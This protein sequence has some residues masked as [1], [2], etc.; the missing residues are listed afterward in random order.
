MAD[1]TTHVSTGSDLTPKPAG[2][3]PLRLSPTF[4]GRAFIVVGATGGIGL[5]LTHALAEAGARLTLV[6]RDGARL[7]TLAHALGAHAVPADATD[8]AAI[9][10]AFDAA[11]A[12]HGRLDGAVNLAG[13]IV[14]KSAHQTSAADYAAVVAQN[15]TTAFAVTRAAGRVLGRA[16]GGSVVLMSSAAARLGLSNHEAI[17]AAKAGI[18]GLTRSAAASYARNGVRFNCVASGLVETPL[19]ARLTSSEVLRKASEAMHPLGRI[20]T[21]RDVAA[22]IGFLLDPANTWVTG[23]VL[24]VDGGLGA[25]KPKVAG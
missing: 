16:G 5:V 23:Q 21:P 2:G 15:L 24:G 11:L 4:A 6:A 10:G 8:F 19:S 13:S 3:E 25:V 14:L 22:A 1:P 17:A 20:G 7:E 9:D 18:E 12:T